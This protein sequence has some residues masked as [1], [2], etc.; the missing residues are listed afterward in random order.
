M[1]GLYTIFTTYLRSLYG[2]F[3]TAVAAPHILSTVCASEGVQHVSSHDSWQRPWKPCGCA[4]A[5]RHVS[6]P[7]A[8]GEAGSTRSSRSPR[9]HEMPL[10]H[11]SVQATA[12]T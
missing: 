2:S 1:P 9:P 10:L 11:L 6:Q 5:S 7:R 3:M 4:H 8:Y 12:V